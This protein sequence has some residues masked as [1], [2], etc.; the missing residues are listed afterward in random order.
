MT[1][2]I[3]HVFKCQTVIHARK[4]PIS[5]VFTIELQTQDGLIPRI[6]L[7]LTEDDRVDAL[8]FL[9]MMKDKLR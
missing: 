5:G 9:K 4:S 6:D 2:E 1:K 8:K 7:H 3:S